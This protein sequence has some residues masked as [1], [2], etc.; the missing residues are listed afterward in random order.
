M[1]SRSV[2]RGAWRCVSPSWRRVWVA[3]IGPR[4]ALQVGIKAWKQKSSSPLLRPSRVS[5]TGGSQSKS[6]TSRSPLSLSPSPSDSSSSA[7][8]ESSSNAPS[9]SESAESRRTRKTSRGPRPRL[10]PRRSVILLF[11]QLGALVILRE[12]IGVHVDL[13]DITVT[14]TLVLLS[15]TLDRRPVGPGNKRSRATRPEEIPHR[16]RGGGDGS[17]RARWT[18]VRRNPW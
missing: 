13:P 9:S 6:T 2:R 17:A 7:P 8:L 12:R 10:R 1:P 4:R 11:G 5:S 16:S 3:K 15:F 18:A 14:V